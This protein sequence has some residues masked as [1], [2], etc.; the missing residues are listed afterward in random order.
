M[1]T[2]GVR[3]D[4]IDMKI[5]IELQ[6]NGRVTNVTLADA[7][8]ITVQPWE[9]KMASVIEKAIRDSDLGLNPATSGDLIRVPMPAVVSGADLGFRVEATQGDVLVGTLVVRVNGQWVETRSAAGP[10]R[11]AA[12]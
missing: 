11:L 1:V 12:R 5:L 3:L 10:K 8:T 7:R 6:N 4:R 2:P 9:K